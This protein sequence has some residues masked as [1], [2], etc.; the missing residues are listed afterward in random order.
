MVIPQDICY[1]VQMNKGGSIL[2]L[3]D[4]ALSNLIL[5]GLSVNIACHVLI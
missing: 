2:A 5:T 3:S 4:P 1:C